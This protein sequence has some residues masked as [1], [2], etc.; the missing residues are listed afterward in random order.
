MKYS[1]H[2]TRRWDDGSVLPKANSKK[3]AQ[4]PE[5]S[6]PE[7]FGRSYNMDRGA[8]PPSRLTK[9]RSWIATFGGIQSRNAKAPPGADRDLP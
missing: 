3:L 4:L 9:L 7:G 2:D 5:L 8:V 1:S 6:A